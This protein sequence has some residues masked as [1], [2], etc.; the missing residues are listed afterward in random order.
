MGNADVV[1]ELIEGFRLVTIIFDVIKS[2]YR[3]DGVA[4][5]QTLRV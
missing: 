4:R 5:R 1:F 3:G 2:C